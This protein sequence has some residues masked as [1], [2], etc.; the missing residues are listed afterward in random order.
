LE[1]VRPCGGYEP[2]IA[3]TTVYYVG[4]EAL[5]IQNEEEEANILIRATMSHN[6]SADWTN[7][8]P[9]VGLTGEGG[10]CIPLVPA[11]E[12]FKG[13]HGFIQVIQNGPNGL[14]YS[15]WYSPNDKTRAGTNH[16]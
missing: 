14:S 9:V 8:W 11:P 1:D 16:F 2:T 6:A 5:Y 10:F 15:V 12:E 4:G 7:L 3:E 13:H